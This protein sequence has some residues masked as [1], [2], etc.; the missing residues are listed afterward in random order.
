[1]TRQISLDSAWDCVE[2][3][4]SAIKNAVLCLAP[5]QVQ[6]TSCTTPPASF[7]FFS[8]NLLK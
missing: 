3:V 4:D 2:T 5:H 6:A 7:I 1:M 8:A